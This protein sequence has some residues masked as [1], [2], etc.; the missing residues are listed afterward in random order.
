MNAIIASTE[1][2]VDRHYRLCQDLREGRI[3]DPERDLFLLLL[4]ALLAE[5]AATPYLHDVSWNG[6]Q[7]DLL[8]TDGDRRWCAVELK[9]SPEIVGVGRSRRNLREK[10]RQR[11]KKLCQQTHEAFEAC[12][13]LHPADDVRAVGLCH[14]A[15]RWFV[16]ASFGERWVDCS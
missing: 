3:F 12:R 4:D 15:G 2:H 1:N 14:D 16:A 6:H 7:F 10:G 5:L 13:R 9:D 11:N 8:F